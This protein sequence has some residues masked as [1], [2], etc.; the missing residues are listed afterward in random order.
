MIART[1]T[2]A[3]PAT[4]AGR[5]SLPRRT[6]ITVNGAVE[7][8]TAA[9]SGPNHESAPSESVCTDCCPNHTSSCVLPSA[10][11][12]LADSHASIQCSLMTA[13]GRM[14]TSSA[15]P[16]SHQGAG[17]SA[18]RATTAT[19]T[20]TIPTNMSTSTSASFMPPFASHASAVNHASVRSIPITANGTSPTI[21]FGATS[22]EEAR[23]LVTRATAAIH[24]SIN[25][26]NANTT[27][28]L[29]MAPDRSRSSSA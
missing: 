9:P 29:P 26:T 6:R 11:H 21:R 14:P 5:R 16:T 2:G 8:R 18:I 27:T 7:A 25:P 20:N 22:H 4:S 28:S 17:C 15:E 3:N 10:S 1:A 24:A 19:Q 12:A 23:G 13:N